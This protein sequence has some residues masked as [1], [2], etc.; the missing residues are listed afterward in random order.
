MLHRRLLLVSGSRR[1][2]TYIYAARAAHLRAGSYVVEIKED[3]RL[4]ARL[5]FTI[6]PE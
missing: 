5:P 2:I 4:V 3:D 6:Q 1:L